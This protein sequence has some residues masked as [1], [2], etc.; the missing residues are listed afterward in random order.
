MTISGL[1]ADISDVKADR[2]IV[3]TEYFDLSG[4]RVSD[5]Y[6]GLII[7]VTR[8]ADGTSSAEKIMK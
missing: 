3:G 4:R 2:K 6:K 5:A 7:R 1:S 8:Y